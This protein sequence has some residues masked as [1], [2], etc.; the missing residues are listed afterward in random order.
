MRQIQIKNLT[1]QIKDKKILKNINLNINEGDRLA[2]LGPNGAGK[3]T[4]VN[5]ILN[6]QKH[7]QGKIINDFNDLPKYKI[8]VHMQESELNSI[9][10][11]KEVLN[12]FLFDG[13]Y[14]DLVEKYSL[15]DKLNQKIGT[16]SGG[17]KQKLQLILA[18]ENDPEII[19][20]D[21]VTTGLDMQSRKSILEFIK[22]ETETK[23]KTLIMVTHYFEEV[24]EL[25]NK[26]AILK[27][28]ELIEYGE[29]SE[30][31]KKYDI[32]KSAFI[33]TN[34]ELNDINE[35]FNNTVINGNLIEIKTE[36]KKDM[37]D[38]LNFISEN[39]DKIKKYT[40]VEP[41]IEK[42]YTKVLE[43]VWYEK[44]FRIYIAWI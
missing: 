8:G 6:L 30:L 27:N 3:T 12:L 38:V 20:I 29:K 21:E 25:C 22:N 34:N 44:T 1:M 14:Q 41:T 28:G 35:K 31:F 17:E 26:I 9:M 18:F 39:E 42:L 19:F 5:T 10:K 24:E 13:K 7:K 32:S 15:K 43:G 11:V 33:E 37:I 16:L 40:I 2:I 36:N 4:L 23:G